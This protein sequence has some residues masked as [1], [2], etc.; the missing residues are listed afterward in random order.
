MTLFIFF[1][2]LFFT[3]STT[4]NK[5]HKTQWL[6]SWKSSFMMRLTTSDV[7]FHNETVTSDVFFHDE[8]RLFSSFPHSG[9][10]KATRFLLYS[11]KHMAQRVKRRE[12]R[13]YGKNW[14]KIV[15]EQFI[16]FFTILEVII[17]N[18]SKIII[19]NYCLIYKLFWINITIY[20]KTC[21]S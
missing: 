13:K 15:I 16:N 5:E 17:N 7:F 3:L 2:F 21:S 4:K 1:F 18:L 9:E 10:H 19:L 14:S 11:I 8:M 12:R 6:S 20:F